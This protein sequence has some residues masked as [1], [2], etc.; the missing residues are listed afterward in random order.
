M[1]SILI[2]AIVILVGFYIS[3]NNYKNR[4]TTINDNL[5]EFADEI[6]KIYNNLSEENQNNFKISL[7]PR[8]TSV[9][10]NLQSNFYHGTS[11]INNLQSSMFLMEDLMKKLKKQNI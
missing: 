1:P 2:L 10:N 9:F 11:N 3:K 4:A 8:E 6:M 7:T 5:L